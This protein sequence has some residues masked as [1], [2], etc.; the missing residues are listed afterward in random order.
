MRS[1]SPYME[2][3]DSVGKVVLTIIQWWQYVTIIVHISATTSW[4]EVIAFVIVVVVIDSK[5][6]SFSWPPTSV[7]V[8]TLLRNINRELPSG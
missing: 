6:Y 5:I 4:L 3:V 1:S 7:A 2:V 8:A